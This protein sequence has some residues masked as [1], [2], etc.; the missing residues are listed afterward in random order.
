MRILVEV[1]ISPCMPKPL[2]QRLMCLPLRGRT[3]RHQLLVRCQVQQVSQ[4]ACALCRA[5]QEKV[6]KSPLD[7][8]CMSGLDWQ[9]KTLQMALRALCPICSA[10]QMMQAQMLVR[11]DQL[12]CGCCKLGGMDMRGHHLPAMCLVSKQA[13][14]ALI[15]VLQAIMSGCAKLAFLICSPEHACSRCRAAQRNCAL[16]CYASGLHIGRS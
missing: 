9:I 10:L 1:S 6:F 5:R 7:C 13:R 4:C 8:S 14:A 16:A 2:Y 12:L 15:A 3:P 11:S